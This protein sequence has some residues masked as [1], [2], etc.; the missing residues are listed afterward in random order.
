MLIKSFANSTIVYRGRGRKLV[1]TPFSTVE[2]NEA[3]FPVASLMVAYG[4]WLVIV[5]PET[6]K[7]ECVTKPTVVTEPTV[8]TKPEMCKDCY[9]DGNIPSDEDCKECKVKDNTVQIVNPE[10]E[11]VKDTKTKKSSKQGKSRKNK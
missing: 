10:P 8:V 11:Q 6:K 9:A 5:K 1:I 3:T 7:V 2:V 4:K